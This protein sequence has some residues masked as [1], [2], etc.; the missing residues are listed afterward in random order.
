MK[1]S[2]C[3]IAGVPVMVN[4]AAFCPMVYH[5]LKKRSRR[6]SVEKQRNPFHP[7][8]TKRQTTKGLQAALMLRIADTGNLL[9]LSFFFQTEVGSQ[10]SLHRVTSLSG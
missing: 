10:E 9:R 7:H 3:T 1:K 6:I 4:I 2:G 8:T 5:Q